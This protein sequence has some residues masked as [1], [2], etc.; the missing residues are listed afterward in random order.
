M[1]YYGARLSLTSYTTIWHDLTYYPQ[2]PA[3]SRRRLW[4]LV[5]DASEVSPGFAGRIKTRMASDSL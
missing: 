5:S 3:H 4:L 2:G 1:L